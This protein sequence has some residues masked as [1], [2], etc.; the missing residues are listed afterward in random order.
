[1]NRRDILRTSIA[2]TLLGALAPLPA[3]AARRKDSGK[4]LRPR[5]LSKGDTVGLI[6]PASNV[7]EDETIR[8]AGDVIRSLGFKL[9]EG[10]YLYQRNQYL[11]GTDRERA[12]DVNA[13][14]ADK[15]VDAIFCIRGGY[16]TTRILPYLDYDVIRDNPKVFLG[17]SDIT[18][19]LIAMHVKT[20]LVSIHGRSASN[21]S[22]YTLA[23]FKK[24]LVDPTARTIIGRPPPI[25]T[26]EGLVERQNR[27]T[28][29]AGG[30]ATGRLIGGNLSLIAALMGTPFEPEFDNR[31]LFL[32]D[33]YEAPYRVDRML[34]QLWLAGKLQQ[35]AGIVFGKFT[36]T[37]DYEGNTFS[38]EEVIRMRCEPLGVPTI[39]GLMIA[40]VRDQTFVPLG[41]N[42]KL[43]ADSGTL[44]LLEPAVL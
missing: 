27:V 23:E 14:F 42:A 32:E 39:R 38:I 37:D 40:H 22:D 9:Q 6:A 18:G 24:V 26:R 16:G 21:Y 41:I 3:H 33:V 35:L 43:D 30:T 11:A 29:F 44:Q 20:G 12:A 13:M 4:I 2:A 19:I 10:K 17:F 5:R 7:S 8:Y 1:M 28:T 34:T 36:Q 15:N 25:E 31:I